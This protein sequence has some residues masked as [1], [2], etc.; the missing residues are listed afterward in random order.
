MTANKLDLHFS[1]KKSDFYQLK[2]QNPLGFDYSL[3]YR[4]KYSCFEPPY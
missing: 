1:S 2:H 4:N 3:F